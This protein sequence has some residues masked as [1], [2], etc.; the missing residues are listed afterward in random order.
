MI[1]LSLNSVPLSSLWHLKSILS[2]MCTATPAFSLFPFAW[3]IFFHCLPFSL[4]V[5]FVLRCVCRQ[6]FVGFCFLIQSTTLC[7]LTRALSP[8]IFKVIIYT[9]AFIALLNL[10]FQ[11]SLHFSFVP[12][13]FFIWLDDFLL[14]YASVLFFLWIFWFWFVTALFFKYVNSFLY[15]L[16][17]LGLGW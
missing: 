4:C 14:F 12:F 1:L 3:N 15:L 5:S 11:L 2:D 6:H 9:Y 16:Y 8:L 17:L 13:C 7:L 10:V